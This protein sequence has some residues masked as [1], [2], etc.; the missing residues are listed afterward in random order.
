MES[1]KWKEPA[2]EKGSTMKDDSMLEKTPTMMDRPI[3]GNRSVVASKTV[4]SP[5]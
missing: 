5:V 2:T 1:V 4:S 3:T